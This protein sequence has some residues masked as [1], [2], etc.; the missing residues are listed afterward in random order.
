MISDGE[1]EDAKTIIGILLAAKVVEWDLGEVGIQEKDQPQT[2]A[3]K[4]R[5][6]N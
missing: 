6:R 1:I 5:L 3:E 4:R 2:D